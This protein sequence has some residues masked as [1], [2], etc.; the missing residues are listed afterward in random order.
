M[1]AREKTREVGEPFPARLSR[2]ASI[3]TSMP[4]SLKLVLLVLVTLLTRVLALFQTQIISTDGVVYVQMAK[5]FSEGKYAEL[6]QFNLYPLIL[7]LVHKIIGDWEL[8]GQLISIA[9]GTLTVVPVFLLGRSLYNEKAGW[10]S[11]VFYITLPDFLRYDSDV[12]RDP[13]SWFFITTTL[14]LVW[15]GLKKNRLGLIGLASISAGLGALTRGEG[16]ILWAA[17][18]IFAA[19]GKVPRVS[20]RRRALNA[21]VL[22]LLFPLLLSPVLWSVKKHPSQMVFG[23]MI[24]F[25]LKFMT[26][27]ARVILQPQDPITWMGPKVYESL[28]YIP[29]GAVDLASRHRVVLA[30]SEVIYKFIKSANLIIVFILLGLWK[31]KKEGVESSDWYLLYTFAALFGMSV[32]YTRQI[33]YFSTRHGL[34]LVLPCLFF[35]GHG[36]EFITETF[37]RRINWLT[38]KLK[39]TKRQ[40]LHIVIFFVI[41]IF[42]A[43]ALLPRR[44]DKSNL[45]EVGL[46]LKKSGYQ[47][48]VI[49]GSRRFFRLVFYAEGKFVEMPDSWGKGLDIIQQNG[50]RIVLVD[51]CTIE[52]ECPNFP[53]NLVGSTLFPIQGPKEKGDKCSIQIYGV[54]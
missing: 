36:L 23:E 13:T 3:I 10:L 22:I 27:H 44:A 15:E 28:H 2:I 33:Y 21:T 51:P 7:F 46:W 41:T 1:L 47:G 8:S 52:Q 43:H 42:L 17:L 18:A 5:L 9:L 29:R 50:V 49:M 14:Y 53:K 26:N 32:F 30:I 25:P 34:T 40:V 20:L 54:Y 39:I 31:R 6:P 11:A 12:L 37:T 35:A 24:S 45:K 19:F 4:L 48:S 38:P 16:F